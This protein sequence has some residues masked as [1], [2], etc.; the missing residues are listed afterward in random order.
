MNSTRQ[1]ETIRVGRWAS[2]GAQGYVWVVRQNW[3][4]YH[5]E[6][7][8]EGPDL[9]PD[10]WA[11]YAVFGTKARMEE[12][13]SRSPTC[14]SEAEAIQRAEGAASVVWEESDPKPR[15]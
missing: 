8:D 13:S 9:G 6:F 10:G 11:Y 12:H 15:R 7:Y 3:D 5:E 4:Y 2:D 1:V 14:L